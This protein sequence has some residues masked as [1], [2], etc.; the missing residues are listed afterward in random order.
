M[1]ADE[2]E[3]TAVLASAGL[4]PWQHRM[5]DDIPVV[6]RAKVAAWLAEMNKT[7][8]LRD[9]PEEMPRMEYLGAFLTWW[10]WDDLGYVYWKTSAAWHPVYYWFIQ[11]NADDP[12]GFEATHD[13][14][15]K[16]FL[17][18][19]EPADRDR[20]TAIL[21][22]LIEEGYEW[23]SEM[24]AEHDEPPAGEPQRAVVVL[25]LD[26]LDEDFFGRRKSSV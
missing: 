16:E 4:H 22:G 20:Y 25:K 23:Y 21:D 9:T 10:Q 13:L 26:T 11:M 8:P 14:R 15:R 2:R 7:V 17:V 18:R 12:A 3:L 1:T 19:L 24:A 5:L 6:N